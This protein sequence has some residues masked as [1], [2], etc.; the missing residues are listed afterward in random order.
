M[1][2]SHAQALM[3]GD[4]PV[5]MRA[6]S[7]NCRRWSPFEICGG[8]VQALAVALQFG[9]KVE[10]NADEVGPT[11]CALDDLIWS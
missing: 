4:V 8:A 1:I 5:R 9:S 7:R 10:Q 11:N 3:K 2:H 6:S